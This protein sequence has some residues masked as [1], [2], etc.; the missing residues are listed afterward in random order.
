VH[1]RYTGRI[2]SR[3]LKQESRGLELTW[4]WELS[5]ARYSASRGNPVILPFPFI[6]ISS[7]RRDANE[8]SFGR[9]V[10]CNP[11]SNETHKNPQRLHAE[12]PAL[13]SERAG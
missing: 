1:I 11:T 7:F 9:I 4:M 10:N 8:G 6:F 3:F 5:I 2:R 12:H 13:S